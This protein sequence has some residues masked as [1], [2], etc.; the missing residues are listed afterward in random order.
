MAGF[1]SPAADGLVRGRSA[2]PV[3]PR[4]LGDRDAPQGLRHSRWYHQRPCIHTMVPCCSHP[5]QPPNTVPNHALGTRQVRTQDAVPASCRASVITSRP[6]DAESN[7][8]VTR[9]AFTPSRCSRKSASSS[10]LSTAVPVEAHT[11]RGMPA[12]IGRTRCIRVVGTVLTRRTAAAVATRAT[13]DARSEHH[14]HDHDVSVYGAH[15]GG[16]TT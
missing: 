12:V 3:D 9:C 6:R 2:F 10:M 4:D 11:P 15:R 16:W 1:R 13:G 8:R 14:H 7:V 5:R